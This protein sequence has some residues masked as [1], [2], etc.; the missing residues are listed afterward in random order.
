M[1]KILSGTN[2]SDTNIFEFETR[3]S[4]QLFITVWTVR[5]AMV[6]C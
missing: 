5:S 4:A 1:A 3:Y 6:H 2:A